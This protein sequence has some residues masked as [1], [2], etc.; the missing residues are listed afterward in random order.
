MT[1]DIMSRVEAVIRSEFPNFGGKIAAETTA[2]DVDGWDSLAHI[3]LIMS[4]ER[5]LSVDIDP[6]ASLEFLNI[7]ELVSYI[8]KKMG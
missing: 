1:D 2:M 4:L 6:E 8:E 5:A 3:G 7:G